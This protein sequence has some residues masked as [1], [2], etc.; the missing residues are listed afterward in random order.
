[1]L[2]NFADPVPVTIRAE[3]GETLLQASVRN[4]IPHF[5]QCGGEARCSTC[6][7]IVLEGLENLTH[8]N[9]K[10]TKLSELRGWTPEIRLA[11]QTKP[12]GNVTLK[13]LVL[14]TDD[15]DLIDQEKESHSTREADLAIL[16]CDIRNFTSFSE[17]NLT[18]DIVHI[19]NKYFRQV[20]DPILS[21][22]GF[23]DKYIGDGLLA[24]FGHEGT[25]PNS[26]RLSALRSALLILRRVQALDPYMRENFGVELKVGIGLHF[27][28]C[29]VGSIGHP[30]K[31]QLTAIGDP[32]NTAS[33]IEGLTKKSGF[34][35]LVSEEFIRPIREKVNVTKRIEAKLK[36]KE[37]NSVLYAV[38]D[39]LQKDPVYLVQSSFESAILKSKELVDVFYETLFRL[40]P[41][42]KN[43]FR[44][45]R[46]ETQKQML[47]N[48][49]TVAIRGFHR[50][51]E[52][53][54]VLKELGQRH[55]GYGVRKEYYPI[56][57]QALVHSLRQ[58]L[59][60]EWSP[61]LENAWEETYGL[62]VEGML[63]GE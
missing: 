55:I 45:D 14:D 39:L 27:G 5:H 23:V 22:G 42:F 7:V 33:R 62:I 36:G 53:T 60:E 4:G 21:N 26:S 43:L 34:P 15:A 50:F 25:D 3:E 2:L 44:L 61:E 13:R 46:I 17:K 24:W 20:C 6:R 63:A 37:E 40:A 56:A 52:L 47:L 28:K 49:L 31:R 54:P 30:S 51:R 59:G 58:V 57:G 41:E 18:Y 1:M 32:V 16:F 11:C 48:M 12:V 8:R 10:E 19:L 29:V 35:L 38:E 9:E